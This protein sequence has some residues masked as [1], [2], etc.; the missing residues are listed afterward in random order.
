[1]R[2]LLL[3]A[4][5]L[6]ASHAAAEPPQY[7]NEANALTCAESFPERLQDARDAI[8]RWQQEAAE[9]ER[10]MP[11]WNEHCRWLSDLEIAIR[12]IDDA[13][14]FVCDTKKGR[15]K[16]LTADLVLDHQQRPTAQNFQK[17]FQPSYLC[18]SFDTA[19]RV[20]IV[21]R[22]SYDPARHTTKEQIREV[23]A[24]EVR[25]MCFQVENE[26]CTKARAAVA[27]VSPPEPRA[28]GSRS[29]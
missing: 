19:E 2:Q 3:I 21:M 13:N 29:E 24:L 4:V 27:E 17:H 20:S 5:L 9:Y 6:T 8:M 23:V 16:G 18:E 11:W 7:A 28:S 26:K 10:I 25:V 14:A 15:P 1:M 22:D 12:K